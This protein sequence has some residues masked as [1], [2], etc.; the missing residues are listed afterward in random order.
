[1][2]IVAVF[3]DGLGG[4]WW[5]LGGID[6]GRYSSRHRIL[7]NVTI[8]REVECRSG[9]IYGPAHRLQWP[10]GGGGAGGPCRLMWSLAVLD[11]LATD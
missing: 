7:R 4:Q 9:V 1:M 3:L 5:N 10:N 2:L 6:A 8:S 11:F